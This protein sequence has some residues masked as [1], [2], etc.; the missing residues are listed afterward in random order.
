MI[1]EAIYTYEPRVILEIT[2]TEE[3]KNG[4]TLVINISYFIHAT[5]E[6]RGIYFPLY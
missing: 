3:E 1:A 2:V 6:K 4:T 5:N